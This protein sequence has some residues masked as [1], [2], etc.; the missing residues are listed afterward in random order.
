MRG[1]FLKRTWSARSGSAKR[2]TF[3]RD[4]LL[5]IQFD[6]YFYWT[7]AAHGNTGTAGL[8]FAGDEV[9]EFELSELF[10]R[11]L[12]SLTLLIGYVQLGQKQ[13][14]LAMGENEPSFLC[15]FDACVREAEEGWSL[16]KN[17]TFDERSLVFHFNPYDVMAFA[18][19]GFQVRLDWDH[20]QDRL[21]NEFK[22]ALAPVL[23]QA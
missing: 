22:T 15:D 9:G 8:N 11:D 6:Y 19:G 7:G 2:E 23:Q 16:L 5:S 3:K 1:P 20:V 17:F 18:Y 13:Q 12:S 4:K 10:S 14:L 21:A